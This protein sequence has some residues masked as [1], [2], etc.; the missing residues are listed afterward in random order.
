MLF[1][2]SFVLTSL[3]RVS[4]CRP[5]RYTTETCG[6]SRFMPGRKNFCVYSCR[7]SLKPP[8]LKFLLDPLKIS[9]P[10]FCLLS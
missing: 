4:L 3:T 8:S 7:S 10:F 6:R 2:R 9:V 5:T 1:M